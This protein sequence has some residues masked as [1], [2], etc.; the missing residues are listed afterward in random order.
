MKGSEQLVEIYLLG[1]KLAEHGSPSARRV[2]SDFEVRF[3]GNE[4]RPSS[5]TEE[6]AD[7]T[8]NV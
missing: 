2:L 3:R 6:R 4:E 7:Q 5:S 1:K 8:T